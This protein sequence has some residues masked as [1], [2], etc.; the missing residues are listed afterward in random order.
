MKISE[1]N[2]VTFCIIGIFFSL[3][4]LTNNFNLL[5]INL[6]ND[7]VHNFSIDTL[8]IEKANALEIDDNTNNSQ[9]INNKDTKEN[10]KNLTFNSS[11]EVSGLKKESN[12]KIQDQKVGEEDDN[13]LDLKN[14][15]LQ[16]TGLSTTTTT[17]TTTKSS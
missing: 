10:E 3:F 11:K 4:L 16:N 8:Q 15:N 2:I 17:T 6:F 7:D 12:K 1:I 9:I 13:N 5:K 14:T